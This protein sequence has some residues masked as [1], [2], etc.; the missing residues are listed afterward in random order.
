MIALGGKLLDSLSEGLSQAGCD[1]KYLGSDPSRV[2]FDTS[3]YHNEAAAF[4]DITSSLQSQ[5]VL[6][7]RQALVTEV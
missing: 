3:V 2:D 5:Q 1:P 6:R 7:W 4:K